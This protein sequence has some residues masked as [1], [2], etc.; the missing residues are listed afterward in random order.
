LI[1][2]KISFLKDYPVIS[3]ERGK[4]YDYTQK[5]WNTD[6][7]SGLEKR[8]AR[9]SGIDGYTRRFLFCLSRIEIQK[10]EDKPPKYFCQIVDKTGDVLIK[11]IKNYDS[12]ND[13]TD[14]AIKL[15]KVFD[16]TSSYKKVKKGAKKFSFTVVDSGKN[17]LAE[18]GIVYSSASDRNDAINSISKKLAADCPGEGMHLVEH[19]LLRPRFKPAPQNGK[20][21][22]ETYKLFDVCLGDN[23]EF[24]GVEDPYSFRLSLVLPYWHE[25]F[26]SPEFRKF[27]DKIARTET[28]AHC[29]IKICF[30]NNTLMNTFE[31]AYKKWM[32]A[33]KDYEQ[34][35][36]LKQSKQDR[37]RLASNKMIEILT[38]IHSEY[39]EAYLYDCSDATKNPVLLNNAI[40]GTYKI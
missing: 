8:L 33:L 24:C 6:N 18:S 39:P 11:S 20:T 28:P 31:R 30:I 23:C 14:I 29:M 22:E 17:V 26:K 25:R 32:E 12:F 10:T 5:V 40:L 1:K 2:D 16:N 27:F 38:V 21:P 34:D 35:L 36:I 4:A 3:M 19:L 13:I 9:L 15:G 37:L 7:V